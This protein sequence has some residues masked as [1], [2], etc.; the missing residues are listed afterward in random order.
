MKNYRL[1]FIRHGLTEANKKALFVGHT[2]YELCLEGIQE[3]LKLKEEYEYPKVE[4]VYSSPLS[5]CIQTAGII[6]PE[7]QLIV[8][9]AL[10]EMDFGDFEGKGYY[11]LYQD[12]D[13]TQWLKDSINGG[14]RGGETG[15][16]FATRVIEACDRIFRDMMEN[17]ITDVA[18]VTHGGVIMTL[19]TALGLPKRQFKEWTTANGR[20]Y[21]V[22]MTPQMWMR[23][24]AFEIAGIIP[25]GAKTANPYEIDFMMSGDE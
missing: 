11:D 14:P 2:D 18:V 13:F 23:D 20:G 16:E 7:N 15:E 24:R 9:K 4:A 8:E 5:R 3:L 1:H 21:T 17:D 12:P 6:Y 25:H 22:I 10:I 19:M